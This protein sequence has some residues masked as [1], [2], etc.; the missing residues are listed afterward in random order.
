MSVLLGI[1]R[2]AV[3]IITVHII[4]ITTVR[5]IHCIKTEPKNPLLWS[6]YK[7]RKKNIYI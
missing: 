2:A 7:H 5:I 3:K 1:K 6:L 4:F